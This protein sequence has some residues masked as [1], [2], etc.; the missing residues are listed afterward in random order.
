MSLFGLTGAMKFLKAI[1]QL[2]LRGYRRNALVTHKSLGDPV[3]WELEGF[4]QLLLAGILESSLHRQDGVRLSGG[5][6]DKL[7]AANLV[8]MSVWTT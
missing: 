5:L 7:V 2:Q 3:V 1:L 4:S 8:N 6:L